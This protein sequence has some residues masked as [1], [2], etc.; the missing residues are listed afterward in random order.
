[1][2]QKNKL[3]IVGTGETAAIAVEM[4]KAQGH[5]EICGFSVEAENMGNDR[6]MDL[7]VV[8]LNEIAEQFPPAEFSVFIAISFV[9]LNQPR[10]R[11]FHQLQRQHYRFANIISPLASVASSATMGSNLMIYDFVS[12]G[13]FCTIADNTTLCSHA[14]ISHSTRIGAHNYLAAGSVIGG[15]CNTGERCFIGLNTTLSDH[16]K[17][18][19]DSIIS[20]T[21]YLQKGSHASGLYSGNPARRQDIEIADF[22]RLKRGIL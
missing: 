17:L 4:V 2:P 7:P 19:D 15:Y 21:G 8:P 3:V 1:M 11:I 14:V 20:A 10:A 22:L 12:V 6:H 5:Y 18:G 13:S 16:C 9:W